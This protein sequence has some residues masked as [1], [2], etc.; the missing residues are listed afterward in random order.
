MKPS[1]GRTRL[2][3]YFRQTQSHVT[4]LTRVHVTRLSL[5]DTARFVRESNPSQGNTTP[6]TSFDTTPLWNM[7]EK[8]YYNREKKLYDAQNSN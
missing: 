5:L 4:T 3:T 6:L 7:P 8:I 1:V 2:N